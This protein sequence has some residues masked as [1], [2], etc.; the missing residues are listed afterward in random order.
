MFTKLVENMRDIEIG[1]TIVMS[2]LYI[3]KSIDVYILPPPIPAKT[4]IME[5]INTHTHAIASLYVNN[6]I[7]LH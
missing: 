1:M 4:L 6:I 3:I 5:M 2:N 7:N